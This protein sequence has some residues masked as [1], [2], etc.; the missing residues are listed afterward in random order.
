[1]SHESCCIWITQEPY[2]SFYEKAAQEMIMFT[3]CDD[4]VFR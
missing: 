2:V 1:M 3:H 4:T